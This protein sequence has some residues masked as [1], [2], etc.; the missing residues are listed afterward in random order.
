MVPSTE[1]TISI[2]TIQSPSFFFG[3]KILPTV[4]VILNI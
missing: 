4:K 2:L 3:G 1:I